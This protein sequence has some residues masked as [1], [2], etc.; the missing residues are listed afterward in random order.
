MICGDGWTSLPLELDRYIPERHM[1]FEFQG[2]QHLTG[3]RRLRRDG[4]KREECERHGIV[5]YAVYARDLYSAYFAN[6]IG[7]P[8]LNLPQLD[9]SAEAYRKGRFKHKDPTASKTAKLP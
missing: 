9:N 2:Q 6:V 4:F 5:L 3:A 1:A 8:V 7:K